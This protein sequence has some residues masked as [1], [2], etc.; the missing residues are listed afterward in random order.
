MN[1][2]TP[3]EDRPDVGVARLGSRVHAHAVVEDVDGE[4]PVSDFLD[5][6]EGRKR[7]PIA[8]S[9]QPADKSLFERNQAIM[10]DRF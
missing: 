1:V 5:A 3:S 9:V 8:D 6:L 4:K 2:I 7:K 10:A